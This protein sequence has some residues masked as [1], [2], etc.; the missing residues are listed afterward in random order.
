MAGSEPCTATRRNAAGRV[1]ALIGRQPSQ[2]PVHDLPRQAKISRGSGGHGSKEVD[3]ALASLTFKEIKA[4]P[5]I[6]KLTRPAVARIGAMTHLPMILID[7][8]TEEGVVG[9]SY[10]KPYLPKAMK[11][12]IPALLDFGEMLKGR[13]VSPVDLYETARKSLHFVGYQ[14]LSM[15]AVAGLDMAA[16][17]ALAKAADVPLCVLLGGSVGPVNAYNSNGLW[18]QSPESAAAEALE[19]LDER[20]G[21]FR[22]LKL[23]LGRAD[24]RE[25]L[26][27]IK[28]VRD[29]IGDNIDLMVDF[30]QALN[31]ADALR[32]CHMI[33]DHGL[34][35]IEEPVIY[36][37]F[38]SCA[39]LTAELKTPIQIGENFYGPR[40]VHFA[41]QK[42]ACDLIMPDFMR[43]GGV[44]GFLRSAAI[45]G[46][47]GIPISTHFYPEVGAHVM[48]VS[49][50]AHFLEWLDWS[51]PVLHRHFEIRNGQVHVPEAPGIGIEWD[52]KAIAAS[53]VGLV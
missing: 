39:R 21:G 35:W 24:P 18:L 40:D 6:C 11:Y 26:A 23:R 15:I 38:D 47:A 42:K 8:F 37:D 51:Y 36:D 10:L 19:L 53:Q 22:A 12:L 43:I 46:A 45:A 30:N 20:G 49:E 14:G 52:E 31:L 1:V 27:T 7:L 33:D 9:R 13:R 4:R 48:R 16:W 28:A 17:D 29:A 2:T 32:R 34:V 50:S 3:V 5:V 41:L 25:D 44:T